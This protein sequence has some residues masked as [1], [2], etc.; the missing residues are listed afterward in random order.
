MTTYTLI[1]I[2]VREIDN[3]R[4]YGDDNWYY[5]IPSDKEDEVNTLLIDHNEE[6][7]IPLNVLEKLQ[8]DGTLECYDDENTI[9][10]KNILEYKASE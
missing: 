5:I 3:G 6:N 2:D 8:L 9:S 10:V 1:V 7:T 4:T